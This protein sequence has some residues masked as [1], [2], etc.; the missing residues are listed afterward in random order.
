MTYEELYNELNDALWEKDAFLIS[1]YDP[2]HNGPGKVETEANLKCQRICRKF[3]DKLYLDTK[4]ENTVKILQLICQFVAGTNLH[5]N[6]ENAY[7]T[8]YDPEVM[9]DDFR[10]EDAKEP[11]PEPVYRYTCRWGS[12]EEEVYDFGTL[13]K[14]QGYLRKTAD[15]HKSFVAGMDS[16][17]ISKDSESEFEMLHNGELDVSLSVVRIDKE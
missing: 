1:I 10:P 2:F 15:D 14:A 4:D 6:M 11:V 9:F 16:Y 7:G 3:A 12:G 8:E 17:E 13:E 5:G